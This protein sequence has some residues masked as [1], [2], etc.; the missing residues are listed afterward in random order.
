MPGVV[1][2][3]DS[4]TPQEAFSFLIVRVNYHQHPPRGRARIRADAHR[5][6]V[7]PSPAMGRTGPLPFSARA[8]GPAGQ[9][10]SPGAGPVAS[11]TPLARF[12]RQK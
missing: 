10:L 4:S 11:L 9:E 5:T 2:H 1:T 6:S 3:P 8:L 12:Q 7:C